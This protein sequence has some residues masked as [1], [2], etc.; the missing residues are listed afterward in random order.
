MTQANWA[1][2]A[3]G[4]GWDIM[5]AS[6]QWA[7]FRMHFATARLRTYCPPNTR[8]GKNADTIQFGAST[9]SLIL[10]STATLQRM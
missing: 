3:L 2:R 9:I 7:G 1:N 6:K 4:P 10:R 5:I 8:S